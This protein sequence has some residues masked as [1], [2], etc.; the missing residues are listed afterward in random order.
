[1][2]GENVDKGNDMHQSPG[3]LSSISSRMGDHTGETAAVVVVEAKDNNEAS[4]VDVAAHGDCVDE[5]HRT[6]G[7]QGHLV[8]CFGE[9]FSSRGHRVLDD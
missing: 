5:G 4:V 2:S 3:T 7:D 9:V 8:S 6:A 1:M